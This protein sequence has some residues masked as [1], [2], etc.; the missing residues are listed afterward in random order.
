MND[1]ILFFQLSVFFRLFKTNFTSISVIIYLSNVNLCSISYHAHFY[2]ILSLLLLPASSTRPIP[3]YHRLQPYSGIHFS[4]V[5]SCLLFN[6]FIPHVVTHHL[7]NAMSHLPH[8]S[9]LFG[10]RQLFVIK[11]ISQHVWSRE[12]R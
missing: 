2:S 4:I 5:F 9:F 1:V 6:F 8:D 11:F 12:R 3:P 7:K 10:R